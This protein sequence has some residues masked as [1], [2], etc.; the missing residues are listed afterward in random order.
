MARPLLALAALFAL[1]IAGAGAG[2]AQSVQSEEQDA[3]QAL[4]TARRQA[5]AAAARAEQLE[6]QAARAVA[7]ADRTA[8]ESAAVAA[9]IQQA[10]AEL[11][12][13]GARIRLIQRQQRQLK[14]RLAERQQPVV[15]LT[16][17]LQ[18]LSRRPVAFALLR[19]GSVEDAVHMRA[20]LQTLIPEVERRSQAL[21]AE[22]ARARALEQQGRAAARDLAATSK[23]LAG[24]RRTLAALE[25]R[26]RLAAR[27]AGGIADREN[28]RALALAE[29]ARDLTALVDRIGQE[30]ELREALAMLPGP[31]MRPARPQEAALP[32][33]AAA[34]V[35]GPAALPAYMLPA[36]GRLV[37]GFG[38]VR[39][40]AAR[41]RGVAIAVR[42]GAQVVSPASG[43]IAF[44][45]PYR[46]YGTIAIIEHGGGWTS[47]VTGLARID[48]RVGEQV[49]AGAPLGLAGLLRP[50]LGLELRR[51][52]EPVNPLDHLAT[53]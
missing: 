36:D 5:T 11:A 10:E 38:E 22:I 25:T 7:A 30:G 34:A 33:T 42:P 46:G 53:R 43:R 50:V 20:L 28:E 9:R 3:R 2:A 12:A 32:V 49:I 39:T 24:R 14:A 48:T 8:R 23:Q 40:G 26:Q 44:A 52:G 15:R 6:A 27:D 13:H 18:R 45:G 17:A 37:S 29:Q 31:V 51:A 41:T 19:P 4:A 16:A 35:P 21:R 1:A 47:V